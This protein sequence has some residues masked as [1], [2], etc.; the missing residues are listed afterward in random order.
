MSFSPAPFPSFL[1]YRLTPFSLFDRALALSMTDFEDAIQA[2]HAESCGAHL[3]VTRNTA[4]FANSP[5]PAM[6]PEDFLARY[7]AREPVSCNLYAFSRLTSGL[8]EN[9]PITPETIIQYGNTRRP[10]EI[11]EFLDLP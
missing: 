11:R 6:T 3:I 4:D 7:A 8:P 1:F 9:T 10:G 5:V 2:A